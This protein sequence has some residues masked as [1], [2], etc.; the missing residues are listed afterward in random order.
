MEAL[1]EA[2]VQNIEHWNS[3]I[4]QQIVRQ[5]WENN[6]RDKNLFYIAT[7]SLLVAK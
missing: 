1:K 5:L 3:L 7:E 4:W 6:S 2:L